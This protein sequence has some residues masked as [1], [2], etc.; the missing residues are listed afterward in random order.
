MVCLG[1]FPALLLS[2]P[3]FPFHGEQ[4][5][6][7]LYSLK[8][9]IEDVVSRAEMVA[10][11]ALE[12]EEA[13]R[14]KQEQVLRDYD[15]WDDPAR[16]N[17]SLADLAD[18]IKVVNDLKDLQCKIE[19][20]KLITQLAEMDVINHQLFQEAYKASVD[21][22]KFLDRYEISKLLSGPYDK[23]GACVIIKAGPEGI[24]SEIWAKK[25]LSMYTRW[26]EKHGCEGR[27]I[28][29]CSC[30]SNGIRLAT[31]EFESEYFFGY[32]SGEKGERSYF[33]NRIKAMNRLKAK[34]L[35]L[36]TD[37]GVLEPNRIK[38]DAV[39]NEWN[40]ETRRY[41]FHPQKLVQDMRTGIQLPDVNSVLDATEDLIE[42]LK[43]QNDKLRAE[44]SSMHE[45][46][47]ECEKLLLEESQKKNELSNEVGRLQNL[48]SQKN[49]VN[50]IALLRSPKT[51][52]RVLSRQK[53][54]T[55]VK[56]KQQNS[57]TK[58]S[59]I[60]DEEAAIAPYGGYQEEQILV[61]KLYSCN[62]I[63][64]A[65]L[66]QKKLG[67]FRLCFQPNMDKTRR[68][69]RLQSELMALMMCGDPG[70]SA[71]P[72]G[73]NIFCWKGTITGSK[74]TVYEGMV[75]KLSLS[76]SNDY[77]F[78]PPKVKFENVCFHPNVDLNGGICLDILQDK[79]SSAYD[80]RTILLSIQSLLG[81]PNN[82][83]PLNPQ[84]AAL[85]SNQEEFKKIVEKTYKPA[86]LE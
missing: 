44:I 31:I 39:V 17:E 1:A 26:A 74:D 61:S 4:E 6:Q 16:S 33:A 37:Q 14:I 75:Y 42:E 10:P 29:K 79:W 53:F 3:G 46:Y 72:E 86:K 63:S 49:D 7:G 9:K 43:N 36:A 62:S 19:D 85:W 76:F 52:S 21:V 60:Q 73:D 20:A 34:L 25:L 35:V 66:L 80:V 81:E 13:R 40:L 45:Q 82:D 41:V 22:S 84:A 8:K 69:R 65:R 2:H 30:S 57:C 78:K 27:I 70:I 71:F 18:A 58:E 24:A 64:S 54:R 56:N 38:R 55:P 32:L 47:A 59:E 28:E 83:S 12:C 67:Q 23:E 15:L 11:T 51:N 50:D 68:S 77:P 48:L 5:R